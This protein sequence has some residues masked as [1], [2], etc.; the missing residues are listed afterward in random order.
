MF[1]FTR[2]VKQEKMKRALLLNVIDPTI[3]GVLI[4]GEKGT[5]KSTAVRSMSQ[6]L[7]SRPAVKGCVYRCDPRFPKRLCADCQEKLANGEKLEKITVPMKV[8]ELPLNATEDRVSG[9]LDLEYVLKTGKKKFEP[10]VLAA[11]NGNILYVD[12]INLLDDHIVDLLLDSAAMGVNY[13]EREGVSFSHPARFVLVGTMNPEEGNL[14]PQLLDRFGLSVEVEGEEEVS[15]RM[16]VI[17]RRLE[18]DNDPEKYIAGCK[19]ELKELTDKIVKARELI[20]KIPIDEKAMEMAARL[21]MHYNMEGH[22]SDLTLIRAA[23]ANAALEGHDHIDVKDMES[24][25]S[26]VLAHRI[27]GKAFEK[28]QF[29][30]S[31][32]R[33]CLRKI[34]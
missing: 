26:L 18:F 25:A 16:E 19:D 1:P 3:G 14:R 33:E 5:A 11:A 29:D 34:A 28:V 27:K 30:D 2:V 17:R 23:R 31:E 20:P 32:V 24:V 13:V 6:F 10:G 15:T 22:R 9:T 7:P 12:E 8:V 21:S 4:K